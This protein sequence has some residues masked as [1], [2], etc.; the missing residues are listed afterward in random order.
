MRDIGTSASVQQ[1]TVVLQ[2]FLGS[3]PYQHMKIFRRN[4]LVKKAGY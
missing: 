2:F 3:D 1:A 4:S